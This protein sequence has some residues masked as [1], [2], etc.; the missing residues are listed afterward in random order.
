MLGGNRTTGRGRGNPD[1]GSTLTTRGYWKRTDA[2]VDKAC[3]KFFQLDITE[4]G[5]NTSFTTE[6]TKLME[7]KRN[8]ASNLELTEWGTFVE[9][10]LREFSSKG[11]RSAG[12]RRTLKRGNILSIKTNMDGG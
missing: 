12:F 10:W 3:D 4:H 5:T 6:R 7:E 1:F 2:E 8:K 9:T 11:D